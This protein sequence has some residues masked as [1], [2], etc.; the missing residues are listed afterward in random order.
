MYCDYSVNNYDDL[1]NV[2]LSV[3][4]D[5]PSAT[6]TSEFYINRS[7][8]T[9][10]YTLPKVFSAIDVSNI[11]IISSNATYYGY[12]AIAY[13]QPNTYYPTLRGD[14]NFLPCTFGKIGSYVVRTYNNNNGIS[15]FTNYYDY[16]ILINSL[17]NLDP[18]KTA[19]V[20]NSLAGSNLNTPVKYIIVLACILATFGAFV[21]IGFNTDTI[22]ITAIMGVL[23]CVFELM[24]FTALGWLQLWI[25]IV[26][27][28]IAIALI[29]LTLIVKVSGDT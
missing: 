26:L 19:N 20:D 7:Q 29:I 17:N 13:T 25:L 4:Y 18:S 11:E 9:I 16:T 22:K 21:T 27:L 6:Y 10:K 1:K 3:K 15:D 14:Y 5:F 28:I 12:N 24:I 2:L 23:V 8:P